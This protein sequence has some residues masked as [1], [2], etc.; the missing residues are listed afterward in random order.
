MSRRA[1][2]GALALLLFITAWAVALG[3]DPGG[4]MGRAFV[5]GALA[6]CAILAFGKS[7]ALE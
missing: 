2:W 1:K 3:G 4:E 6:I 7:G 5:S